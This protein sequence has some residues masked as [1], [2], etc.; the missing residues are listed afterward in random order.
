MTKAEGKWTAPPRGFF[1]INV[2]GATSENERNSSVGVVI[3]DVNGKVLAACCSYLQGQYS[4]EEV[5]AMAMERGVL[6]AKD[7]KFPHI[8]LE[9]DALNVVSNITSAN[10][11]GC[12]GHVYHGILGLLSS[13]SSWSVKHVRRDYNKAAHLLAQYARQKEESYVWKGFCPPVVVQVI[14]EEDV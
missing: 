8:I 6:L 11:S 4:V 10:F 9:S 7:L 2:D 3:R 1:K 5:E 13:F 12:L 14:Q